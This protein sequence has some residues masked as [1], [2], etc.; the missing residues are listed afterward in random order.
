MLVFMV[1]IVGFVICC[2]ISYLINI[3]YIIISKIYKFWG[4]N[5][6]E[7]FLVVKN[8]YKYIV[9]LVMI[10]TVVFSYLN[11]QLGMYALVIFIGLIYYSA[12]YQVMF[13]NK[14]SQHIE[15]NF[16]RHM[17]TFRKFLIDGSF[18]LL[19]WFMSTFFVFTVLIS[20]IY[21]FLPY[22]V[23]VFLASGDIKALIDYLGLL[24]LLSI[25][26]IPPI[27]IKLFTWPKRKRELSIKIIKALLTIVYGFVVVYASIMTN[28]MSNHMKLISI[29]LYIIL[30]F[31][32]IIFIFVDLIGYYKEELD[33][34]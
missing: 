4:E 21:V 22:Q 23:L 34:K 15:T 32:N 33:S 7:M 27:I 5:K 3:R 24:V 12:C 28:D 11:E 8:N 2:I 17:C 10:A 29:M 9:I 30:L 31:F 16:F 1:L 26:I 14:K 20:F 18:E 25:L 13:K 19:I 6:E